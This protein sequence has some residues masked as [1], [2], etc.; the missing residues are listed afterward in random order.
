LKLA[1]A[2]LPG[3]V[4]GVFVAPLFVIFV[5]AARLRVAILTISAV[6]AVLLL[7]K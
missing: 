3:V 5:N 7:L 1:A 4:V 2:L 6:S